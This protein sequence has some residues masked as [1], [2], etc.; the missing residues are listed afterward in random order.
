MAS[1][2]W[3]CG[4]LGHLIEGGGTLPSG[5]RVWEH[6]VAFAWLQ[7][8]M[9]SDMQRGRSLAVGLCLLCAHCLCLSWHEDSIWDKKRNTM[10]PFYGILQ[11]P[12]PVTVWL[13]CTYR[14]GRIAILRQRLECLRLT[15]TL[16]LWVILFL[17]AFHILWY[18]TCVNSEFYFF[19]A[20]DSSRHTHGVCT[21][22]THIWREPPTH[23][24]V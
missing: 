17:L 21:Q 12:S 4:S 13:L 10:L 22:H 24:S 15:G 2:R 16:Q 11:E 8:F 19:S 5:E 1:I 18:S 20:G 23:K 9:A 3:Y 14:E 7:C 6:G